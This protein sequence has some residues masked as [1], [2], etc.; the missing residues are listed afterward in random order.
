MQ[1]LG[2]ATLAALRSHS[3]ILV[4]L[5][6][7]F[8]DLSQ[9]RTGQYGTLVHVER[10]PIRDGDDDKIECHDPFPLCWE[11][12]SQIRPRNWANAAFQM[13]VIHIS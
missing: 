9:F 4:S 3:N 2:A 13:G 12:R 1:A 6:D 8:S 7:L 10:V 11:K 5:H